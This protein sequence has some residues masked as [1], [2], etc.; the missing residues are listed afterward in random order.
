LSLR[1]MTGIWMSIR[2]QERTEQ[3]AKEGK[4]GRAPKKVE[5]KHTTRKISRYPN[6]RWRRLSWPPHQSFLDRK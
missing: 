6:T 2:T 1:R 5:C 3:M 4:V